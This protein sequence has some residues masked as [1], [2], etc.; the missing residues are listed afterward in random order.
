MYLRK[1]NEPIYRDLAAT[2]SGVKEEVDPDRESVMR[3]SNV[4]TLLNHLSAG[5]IA[6]GH[7]GCWIPTEASTPTDP[8]GGRHISEQISITAGGMTERFQSNRLVLKVIG[9]E[10]LMW[11]KDV[12]GSH[13]CGHSSCDNPLHIVCELRCFNMQRILCPGSCQSDAGDYICDHGPEGFQCFGH[14]NCP[15]TCEVGRNIQQKLYKVFDDEQRRLATERAKTARKRAEKRIA[16]EAEEQLKAERKEED[17]RVKA[18]AKAAL[19]AARDAQKQKD[20]PARN[21]QQKTNKRTKV[22]KK[23]ADKVAVKNR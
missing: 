19:F 11:N 21:A 5:R 9:C 17:D 7:H 15:S 2:S 1:D 6:V 16:E 8:F 22:A 3:Q 10:H 18:A 23:G 4:E 13:L 12:Q 14:L 20:K